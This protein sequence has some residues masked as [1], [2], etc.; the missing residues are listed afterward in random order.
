MHTNDVYLTID[1]QIDELHN[2]K[3]NIP[4][5]AQAKAVLSTNNYSSF[6]KYYG[7]PF[8]SNPQKQDSDYLP[9]ASF[10]EIFS[11]CYFNQKIRALFLE[12]LLI[13][14]RTLKT[15]I[16]D[17]FAC[18]F[19][20]REYWDASNYSI[21]S[22]ESR[23][24][25]ITGQETAS[26]LKELHQTLSKEIERKYEKNV[27][28]T[29]FARYKNNT[30]MIPIWLLVNIMSVG[31]IRNFYNCLQAESQE[32]ISSQF[33]MSS[34]QLETVWFILNKFRNACAHDERIDNFYS[35]RP[36][37]FGKMHRGDAVYYG[38][39]AVVIIL[40]RILPSQ[41]FREFYTRLNECFITLES[42]IRTI[43]LPDIKRTMRFPADD[44]V[45]FA[46]LG[47][48]NN[49]IALSP[50]EFIAVLKRYIIP[51]IP[52]GKIEKDPIDMPSKER[53]VLTIYDEN[54][55]RIFFSQSYGS[56]YTVCTEKLPPLMVIP[57]SLLDTAEG[58]LRELMSNIQIVWN[59]QKTAALKVR[60]L[61]LLFTSDAE[62]AYQISM[63]SMLCNQKTPRL[64]MELN[65]KKADAEEHERKV[66][67]DKEKK[68]E[69][70]AEIK[71]FEESIQPVIKLERQQRETLYSVLA[72]FDQWALKTYEGKHIS[73]GVIVDCEASP[74]QSFDY[75]DFL[76]QNYSATISDG[77]FSYVEIYADGA[78]H[79][80]IP[81]LPTENSLY[82]IPYPHQGFAQ[83]CDNG[84]IGVLLTTEG[85]IIIISKHRLAYSKH[86][87]RWTYN[88][89]EL[90]EEVIEKQLQHICELSTRKA[91]AQMILQTLVDVSYSHGGACIA[92]AND[93]PL[94]T[95]LLRMTYPTLL[96]VDDR[97]RV[98]SDTDE[99]DPLTEDEKK[100]DSF[101]LSVLNTLVGLDQPFHHLNSYLRR[102]LVEMDGALILGADAKVY[103]VASIV[104]TN[105]ASVLSG[106]RTTAAVR[107]S[108]Y[109][110]A[111]K[112]SQDG[113]MT[114]YKNCEEILSI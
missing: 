72:R 10:K 14:E 81:S 113:Y 70:R 58:H 43:T 102:E 17:Y 60:E 100:T 78:Y 24:D 21:Q 2:R 104:N 1:Q 103:A 8:L 23:K 32:S 37:R 16:A 106:A 47:T 75:I 41:E 105:G 20:P 38:V 95:K 110:L 91:A 112:V 73:L 35:S 111:I 57:P 30:N 52:Q 85:D 36:L 54:T 26:R 51:L 114:F 80:H 29:P 68:E 22:K 89:F 34:E 84:K 77:V 25:K 59:T 67:N 94:P 49:G 27:E 65:K 55:S 99:S 61:E 40:K 12:Y 107:L 13:V 92:I 33:S 82:A 83:A 39:Y 31:T 63:C 79:R 71:G 56:P 50:N 69:I 66:S 42:S 4:D 15:V 108:Q 19:G 5:E 64:I 86:N 6:I 88:M 53:S 62:I 109:G 48:Y 11:L 28:N 3:L 44:D 96:C 76:A 90:A 98:E 97:A 9:G 18:T 7:I 93:K 87:G 46:D 74:N 101:R 45:T